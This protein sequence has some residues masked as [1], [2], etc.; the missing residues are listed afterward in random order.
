MFQDV[1][2]EWSNAPIAKLCNS[3]RGWAGRMYIEYTLE[4]VPNSKEPIKSKK[5]IPGPESELNFKETFKSVK[6]PQATE[7]TK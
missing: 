1:H 6:F 7:P 4:I 5:Y 3:Y 2:I